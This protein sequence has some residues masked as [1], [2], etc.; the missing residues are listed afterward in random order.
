MSKYNSLE[1]LHEMLL[2]ISDYKDD[3]EYRKNF[4]QVDEYNILSSITENLKDLNVNVPEVLSEGSFD[5]LIESGEV[6]AICDEVKA[7]YNFDL[8]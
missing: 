6:D 1:A 5:L 4:T 2:M 8:L 3:N 7:K